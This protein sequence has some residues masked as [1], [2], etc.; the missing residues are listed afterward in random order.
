MV[1][2]GGKPGNFP[3][4]GS[5]LPSHWFVWKLRR[6]VKGEGRERGKGR[7]GRPPALLPPPTGF[8]LKYH[9]AIMSL[10]LCC[11]MRMNVGQ[12]ITKHILVSGE[13]VYISVFTQVSTSHD[14]LHWM[15]HGMTRWCGTSI[16]TR[17]TQ[18]VV[19]A[20]KALEPQ[21]WKVTLHARIAANTCIISSLYAAAM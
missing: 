15:I 10:S 2:V 8:C 1:F 14:A 19:I 21:T 11:F 7:V 17:S 12:R 4:T 13:K 20:N 5:D 18:I 9:P 16:M 6:N 3:L